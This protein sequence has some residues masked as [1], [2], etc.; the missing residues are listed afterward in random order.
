MKNYQF[1]SKIYDEVMGTEYQ[2]FYEKILYRLFKNA[3]IEDKVI[4]E[5]GCGTGEI[6]KRLSKNNKT[7]GI[8]ISSEMIKVAQKK[9]KET[10]YIVMDMRDFKLPYLYDIIFCAF[11]SINHIPNI[12]E[13]EKV[14]QNSKKHLNDNGILIFDFN[15]IE[16]FSAI[17]NKTLIKNGKDFYASISTKSNKN[18]CIWDVSIFEKEKENKY[19]LYKEKIVE[20]SFPI[21]DVVEKVKKVFGNAKIIKQSKGRVFVLAKK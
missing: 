10:K 19:R 20:Y 13:W 8:D 5:L 17:N 1:F 14:F 11:D 4:L 18:K 15:T 2:D 6:I 16:K 7:F 21:D 3:P 9:D 12:S